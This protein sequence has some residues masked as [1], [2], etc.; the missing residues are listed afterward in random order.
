LSLRIGFYGGAGTVTGSKHLLSAGGENLLVDCGMFQGLKALRLMNW[1][2]PPFDATSVRHIVLT[3]AHIDHTGYLPRFVRDGFR[4]DILCTSATKEIASVLLLDAAKLQEEDAAHANRHG[5]SK[6]KPALP[7]F[8]TEDAERAISR[9][10]AVAYEDEFAAG[11][12]FRVRLRNSGHI[13][14]AGFAEVRVRDAGEERT[15]VFSGDLGR[16]GVPLHVDPEAPPA[17][18]A[19]LIESTYGDRLHD[20]TPLIDQIRKPFSECIRRHGTILVPAFAVARV[21]LLTMMIARMM[22]T[23]ELP[24]VPMHIDSPMAVQATKIYGRH[25]TTGELD[26]DVT[27]GAWRRIYPEH[28]QLLSTVDE[29]KTLNDLPG[30]RIIIAPSGMMTGGR[31]LHHLERLAPNPANLIV[32]A[33]YQSPGTR[34]AS[35]EHGDQTLRM[36]GR[37]V[38][39]RAKTMSLQGLSAHADANE[40]MRWLKSAAAPPGRV[41]VTHGEPESAAALAKRIQGEMGLRVDVP[42]LGSESVIGDDGPKAPAAP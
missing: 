40:L 41:F 29:S 17:C 42:G 14:G 33:G 32:L 5:F 36:H 9:L 7:L 10:R 16:Y 25:L 23:G 13:L 20:P 6:H 3:H 24:R 11:D 28:A 4:G 31:V 1:Q 35:L 12:A 38:P 22:D 30:P 18:D 15:I 27:S 21:Q 2:P 19:M 26:A 8:T 37:M 34:G 39:V